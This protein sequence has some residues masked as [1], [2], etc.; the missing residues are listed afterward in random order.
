VRQLPLLKDSLS[1]SKMRIKP[2]KVQAL[3]SILVLVFLW[4]A[5]GASNCAL[6]STPLVP[7]LGH[8]STGRANQTHTLVSCWMIAVLPL[9]SKADPYSG[10][11]EANL[12]SF[13]W[14]WIHMEGKPTHTL[15][16]CWMIAALPPSP[17]ANQP[18]QWFLEGKPWFLPLGMNPHGGQTKH[19]HRFLVGWLQPCL[20][21][22]RRTNSYSVWSGPEFYVRPIRQKHYNRL[23]WFT[24]HRFIYINHMAMIDG[25]W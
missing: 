23:N 18:V 2:Q 13:P 12:N 15:V 5:I 6:P 19:I 4:V 24:K 9:P 8:G 17:K 21:H 25:L 14:V 3:Y 7:S 22:P 11:L 16:P 10:S 20:L 1:D